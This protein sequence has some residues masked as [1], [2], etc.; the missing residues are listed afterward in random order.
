LLSATAPLAPLP[1]ILPA[2]PA[3]PGERRDQRRADAVSERGVPVE[4][5]V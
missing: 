2:E 1:S 4:M 3:Y 5:A